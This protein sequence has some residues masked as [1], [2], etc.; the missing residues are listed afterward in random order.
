MSFYDASIS[1]TGAHEKETWAVFL[2]VSLPSKYAIHF[3]C[4]RMD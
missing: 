1:V 2:G 4:N 3:E